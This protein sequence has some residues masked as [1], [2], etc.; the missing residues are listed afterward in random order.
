MLSGRQVLGSIDNVHGQALEEARSIDQEIAALTDRF[1][2]LREEEAAAYRSLARLRLSDLASGGIVDDLTAAE[3]QAHALLGQRSSAVEAVDIKLAAMEPELSRLTQERAAL[4]NDVEEKTRALEA[5]E[6]GA[7]NQL[8]ETEDYQAQFAKTEDSEKVAH[9]AEQKTQFAEQDRVE[10][11]KPYEDD[12]LFMYLWN[13]GFGTSGYTGSYIARYFDRWVARLID[14]D[15]A[16][17]NYSML[18]EIP[19][20]LH[21]HAER[22]RAQ[23][24]DEA[25]RLAEMEQAILDTAEP[26]DRRKAL[27]EAQARLDDLESRMHEIENKRAGLLEQRAE[28]TSGGDKQ[29]VEALNV[30]AASLKREELQQL[31]RQAQR[32]PLPEDDTV[33]DHIA[34]IEAEIE[35]VKAAVNTQKAL[36]V[37]QR[38]R[39]AELE[40]VRQDYRQPGYRGDSWDFR[41]AG[42]LTM[43]LTQLLSGGLSRGGL[44][45][46]M[47]Q[48]RMPRQ[49]GGFGRGG[50]PMPRFPGGLGGGAPRMPRMPRGGLGG[51]GFRTGGGF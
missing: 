1:V 12:P 38:K 26:A 33:V 6:E 42:M 8:S 43:M 21:D 32:T 11:G 15:K 39:M 10:K 18:L 7:L 5:A 16:R 31:R 28:L 29:T 36:Q 30:I 3:K 23:A 49:P 48:R 13:R 9:H 47:D 25:Q 27:S 4:T 46:Q 45:D 24:H 20:R 14:F 17:A 37:E 19:K 35:A 44:S 51:G 40:R 2:K 22:R 41:D 34:D 50:F